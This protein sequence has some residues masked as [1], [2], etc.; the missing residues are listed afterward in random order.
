MTHFSK[1]SFSQVRR[2]LSLILGMCEQYS[3]VAKFERY[4]SSKFRDRF[5]QRRLVQKKLLKREPKILLWGCQIWKNRTAKWKKI[6]SLPSFSV[7]TF[8]SFIN[9]QRFSQNKITRVQVY[10]LLMTQKAIDISIYDISIYQYIDISIY[11]FMKWTQT[12]FCWEFISC[13][14]SFFFKKLKYDS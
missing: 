8:L 14:L 9:N 2:F 12:R 10:L 6:H 7:P 1:K 3:I 5:F 4:I 13:L 11:R